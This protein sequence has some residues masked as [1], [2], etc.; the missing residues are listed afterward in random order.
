MV[1]P[2]VTRAGHGFTHAP[3]FYEGLFQSSQLLVKKII[4]ELDET[5]D[6]VG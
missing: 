1:P 3:L 4:R 5:N 2:G 6:R